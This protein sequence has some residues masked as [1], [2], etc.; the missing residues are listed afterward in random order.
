MKQEI[1]KYL[2]ALLCISILSGCSSRESDLLPT[3][4][5]A[6]RVLINEDINAGISTVTLELDAPG[7]DSINEV[8]LSREDTLHLHGEQDSST[9]KKSGYQYTARIN[10]TDLDRYQISLL[11]TNHIDAPDTFLVKKGQLEGTYPDGEHYRPSD[12]IDISWRFLLN[13]GITGGGIF[14]SSYNI[15][16]NKIECFDAL[17]NLVEIDTNTLLPNL[18]KNTNNILVIDESNFEN[19][20]ANI[21]TNILVDSIQSVT[22][23]VIIHCNVGMYIHYYGELNTP[24][25]GSNLGLFSSVM[26]IQED[27]NLSDSSNGNYRIERS[28]KAFNIVLEM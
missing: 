12:T 19:I 1:K 8:T 20:T 23:E 25:M 21:P 17:D 26:S 24:D 18:E 27:S 5:I 13:Q 3:S 10:E 4:A 14:V 16:F 15:K 28:E 6:Y 2:Y 7:R 9:F 22:Q 11:R